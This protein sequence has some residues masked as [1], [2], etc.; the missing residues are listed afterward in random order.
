MS[1][2]THLNTVSKFLLSI[3]QFRKLFDLF[4]LYVVTFRK[5]FQILKR[6]LK[7]TTHGA[8]Q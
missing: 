6:N 7:T 5:R 2:A 3:V 1:S 4:L 8:L